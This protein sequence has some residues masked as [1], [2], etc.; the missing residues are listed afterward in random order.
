MRLDRF[1]PGHGIAVACCFPGL[2]PNSMNCWSGS[3]NHSTLSHS[4][5]GAPGMIDACSF[6]FHF[7]TTTQEAC[8]G[9]LT[10][11]SKSQ[12]MYHYDSQHVSQIKTNSTSSQMTL[13]QQTKDGTSRVW[14]QS[15]N[16]SRWTPGLLYTR[17]WTCAHLIPI[18]YDIIR[19][20][21][22]VDHYMLKALINC[23]YYRGLFWVTRSRHNIQTQRTDILLGI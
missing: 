2:A 20:L 8:A 9:R 1:R 3:G 6:F 7:H 15:V 5:I 22:I 14:C 13:I 16:A 19:R 10:E 12:S 11:K 23:T 4:C 21:N 18:E 17:K